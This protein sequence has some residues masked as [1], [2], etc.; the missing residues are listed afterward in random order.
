MKPGPV[1][2]VRKCAIR[3]IIDEGI[4]GVGPPA[5]DP[6]PTPE[7][8][9]QLLL[10]YLEAQSSGQAF[11][12]P[13]ILGNISNTF[14]VP[15]AFE[16]HIENVD[17]AQGLEV[18]KQES[19]ALAAQGSILPSPMLTNDFMPTNP[20]TANIQSYTQMSALPGNLA[21]QDGPQPPSFPSPTSFE[22]QN[23]IVNS[24]V[25]IKTGLSTAPL[26]ARTAMLTKKGPEFIVPKQ[27]M[28]FDFGRRSEEN[29]S[30][31]Q[32]TQNNAVRPSGT[33]AIWVD[34]LLEPGAKSQARCFPNLSVIRNE[35][36]RVGDVFT[37]IANLD[38]TDALK[39]A[40][41]RCTPD[42]SYMVATSRMPCGM[43]FAD[44]NDPMKGYRELCLLSGAAHSEATIHHTKETEEEQLL[45]EMQGV[46]R[47]VPLIVLYIYAK[48]NE[49]R[50]PESF[51]RSLT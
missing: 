36:L 43:Q 4:L 17:G 30:K 27:P 41:M 29:P 26:P 35:T 16:P 32:A 23:V 37:S 13:N 20:G 31:R 28:T 48:H 51:T 11:T 6:T 12:I 34:I 21:P 25:D 22:A 45:R 39:V 19:T 8:L 18:A 44:Y 38:P 7:S 33:I 5:S 15:D 2:S 50:I 49:V 42:S 40:V 1:V 47:N 3:N 10:Y 9:Q 14:E 46:P 24:G